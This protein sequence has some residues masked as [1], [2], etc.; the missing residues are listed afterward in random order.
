MQDQSLDK[1]VNLIYVIVVIIC[2]SI[3]T[4]ASYGGLKASLGQLSYL[5]AALI[6]LILLASDLAMS[7][8]RRNRRGVGRI[9]LAFLCA[10]LFSTA[11]NFNYF[12]S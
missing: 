1:V 4:W 2:V 7:S 8:A 6:G 11:S 9:F 5:G 10:I 3:S 12:Y